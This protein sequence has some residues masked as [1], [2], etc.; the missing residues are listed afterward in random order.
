MFHRFRLNQTHEEMIPHIVALSFHHL[1]FTNRA[2]PLDDTKGPP[3]YLVSLRRFKASKTGKIAT[4]LKRKKKAEVSE[5]LRLSTIP[6]RIYYTIAQI[7]SSLKFINSPLSHFRYFAGSVVRRTHARVLE[8]KLATSS[9]EN[10]SLEEKEFLQ[11]FHS[12]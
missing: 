1:S 4:K 8:C 11:P 10:V 9:S 7:L 6:I 12:L 3:L 2:Y 5:I